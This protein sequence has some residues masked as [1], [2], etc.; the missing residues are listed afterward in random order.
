MKITHFLLASVICVTALRAN[1][2]ETPHVD[3]WV[4]K[5]EVVN[6]VIEGEN[7]YLNLPIFAA[8]L[9]MQYERWNITFK[10][11]RAT[12]PECNT[13]DTETCIHVHGQMT[14]WSPL[15][16]FTFGKVPNIDEGNFIDEHVCHPIFGGVY[17]G[18]MVNQWKRDHED[19]PLSPLRLSIRA[20]NVT[21]HEVG[22]L[23]G[24]WHPHTYKAY[25]MA[26]GCD[27]DIEERTRWSPGSILLLDRTLGRR[28]LA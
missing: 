21:A 27:K 12:G 11:R 2:D 8:Q 3:K 7:Q 17:L 10:I 1:A 22:H 28:K 16:G 26:I 5:P 24:L 19:E 6:V 20:A 9:R 18:S 14:V 13:P 23:L 25:I 15:T 4:A